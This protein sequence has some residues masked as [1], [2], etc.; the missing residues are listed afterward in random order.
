MFNTKPAMV[1]PAIR[2][3]TQTSAFM[4]RRSKAESISNLE[5][6]GCIR[7]TPVAIS[8]T[9]VTA[10]SRLEYGKTK[11]RA[12]PYCLNQIRAVS[13]GIGQRLKVPLIGND[14]GEF[15]I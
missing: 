1:K 12:R 2:P 8:P 10:A 5:K 4:S 15:L 14:G 11:R 9:R 3:A 6:Y 13:G 7:P